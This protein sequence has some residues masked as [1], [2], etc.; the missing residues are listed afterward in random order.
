MVSLVFSDTGVP[1]L[2]PLRSHVFIRR[3][4]ESQPLRF[5]LRFSWLVLHRDSS[6]ATHSTGKAKQDL[7][8]KK[9]DFEGSERRMY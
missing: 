1:F 2:K 7:L 8:F 4:I 3:Q 5:E 9:P 6:Q